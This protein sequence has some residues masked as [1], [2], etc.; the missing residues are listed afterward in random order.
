MIA[1]E[2]SGTYLF[3]ERDD[4]ILHTK[5]KFLR[6]FFFSEMTLLSIA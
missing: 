5:R 6:L 3:V 1:A 4:K 2:D